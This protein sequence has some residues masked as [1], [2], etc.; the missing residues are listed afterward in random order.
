MLVCQ[1]VCQE[2]WSPQERWNSDTWKEEIPYWSQTFYWLIYEES[3]FIRDRK[4]D[5][6]DLLQRNNE[7]VKTWHFHGKSEIVEFKQAL[8]QWLNSKCTICLHSY[9]MSQCRALSSYMMCS[10][11]HQIDLWQRSENRRE[12]FNDSVEVISKSASDLVPH[13]CPSALYR[14]MATQLSHCPD[15]R[16]SLRDDDILFSPPLDNN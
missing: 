7:I 5:S 11:H 16:F 10:V 4:I 3:A 2:F 15:C 12:H 6:I 14:S 8:R 13:L 1:H 9:V